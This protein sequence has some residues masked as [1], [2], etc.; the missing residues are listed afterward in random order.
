M[1]LD[2][3]TASPELVTERMRIEHLGRVVSGHACSRFEV[4]LQA[5][6]LSGVIINVTGWT[7]DALR[8]LLT[9]SREKGEVIA[10]KCGTK[11][12]T[13]IIH[14][15]GPLLNALIDALYTGRL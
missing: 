8:S 13:P 3:S 4:L 7:Q 1:S 14:P 5:F 10:L 2:N 11:F 15:D 12:F 9:T 6:P